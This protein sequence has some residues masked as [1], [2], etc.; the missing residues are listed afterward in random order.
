MT[1]EPDARP[2]TSRWLTWAQADRLSRATASTEDR[3]EDASQLRARI[4]A[5]VEAA[6]PDVDTVV[7]HLETLIGEVD[8]STVAGVLDALDRAAK[9]RES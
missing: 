5:I 3:Q 2:D 7:D 1:A 6:D 4:R 8:Q 9:A